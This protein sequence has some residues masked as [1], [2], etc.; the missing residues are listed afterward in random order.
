MCE[1]FW[2]IYSNTYERVEGYA[3]RTFKVPLAKVCTQRSTERKSFYCK[4]KHFVCCLRVFLDRKN[5]LHS[6]SCGN[7]SGSYTEM[8]R[9]ICKHWQWRKRHS[10]THGITII[11]LTLFVRGICIKDVVQAVRS[12][13]TT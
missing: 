9:I 5:P 13:Q 12:G 7:T 10:H 4:C 1:L 3:A 11:A 8:G 2:I 6:N